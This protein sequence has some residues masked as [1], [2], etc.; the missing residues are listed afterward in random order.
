M[1][2]A[3]ALFLFAVP[4]LA[5]TC[6]YSDIKAQKSFRGQVFAALPKMKPSEM[7]DPLPNATVKL[8]K[9]T[10]G[11]NV[12]IAEAVA[13]ENGRF[14]LENIKPGKYILQAHSPTLQD[15][16]VRIKISAGSGRKK[17]EIVIGLPLPFTCCEGYIE[18][19][20]AGTHLKKR[21]LND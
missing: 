4:A 14:M 18:V 17:D 5:C 20:K 11:E 1:G 9:R 12:V 16:Y 3:F 6:V 19:R 10:D 13:D 8:I 15:I 7:T 2:A 21:I